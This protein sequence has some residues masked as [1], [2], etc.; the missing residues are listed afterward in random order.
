MSDVLFP[1]PVVLTSARRQ[2]PAGGACLYAGARR[3]SLRSSR[4][5]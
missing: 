2:H 3:W 5:A 4:A 1:P